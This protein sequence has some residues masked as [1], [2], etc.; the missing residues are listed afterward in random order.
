[1]ITSKWIPD[2]GA[3]NLEQTVAQ[4]LYNSINYKQNITYTQNI[5]M[6]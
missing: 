1:M 3:A 6:Y 2:D 5:M 4:I